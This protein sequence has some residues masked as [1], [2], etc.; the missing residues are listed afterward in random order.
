MIRVEEINNLNGLVGFRDSL[1]SEYAILDADNKASSSGLF[2]NDISGLITTKN[3]KNTLENPNL[4]D[5]A[6]NNYL[7]GRV[8]SSFINLMKAIYSD[9]DMIENK[10]LFQYE[11]DF[12]KLLEN[13]TDFVGY[14]ID[15]AKTKDV[16]IVL[17]KIMLTFDSVEDIKVLLFHSSMDAPLKFDTVSTVAKSDTHKVLNWNLPNANSI[18]GGKFYIGYLRSSLTGKAYNREYES[19]SVQSS[20]NC[21]GITP[22]KVEGWDNETLFDVNNVEYCSETWGI[23]LDISSYKDY[24]SIIVNNKDRYARGLQLQTAA[25]LLNLI[26]TNSN[27]NET[28]RRIKIQAL[29]D[30]NGNRSN[31]EIPYSVGVLNQLKNEIKELKKFINPPIMQINTL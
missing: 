18:A 10:T 8:N 14:E 25:D 6:F 21:L 15:V 16:N 29:Y 20:F 22:I 26:A 3:I 28:E 17:N 23:N 19:S 11:N 5:E 13:S 30:L 9:E 1:I 7:R 27:S 4:E 12:T 31:P 2:V 24:T